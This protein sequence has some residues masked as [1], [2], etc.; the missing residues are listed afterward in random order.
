MKVRV[1]GP[2][3]QV[4]RCKDAIEGVLMG[5]EPADVLAEMDGAIIV[6][7]MDGTSIGMLSREK[8]NI[9]QKCNI[10]LE[11]DSRSIRIWAKDDNRDTAIAARDHI[12]EMLADVTTVETI[13]VR[14][15]GQKVAE[16]LNSTSMRQLQDSSGMTANVAKDDQ[17]TA[18][19]LTGLNGVINEA[20]EL[21][22]RMS[23]G[24]GAEFLPLQP[25]LL[26]RMT[27]Q[28]E[29]DFWRDLQHMSHATGAQVELS[30]GSNR[31]NFV[32]N[33][34]CTAHAKSELQKILN[35]YF[36][37]SCI[38]VSVPSHAVDYIAGDEDRELMRLQ[39]RGALVAL[40]RQN[41]QL[42]LCG[43]PRGV[44]Q[45]LNR[46][47]NMLQQWEKEYW[48]HHC[49]RGACYAVIGTGGSNIRQL[50]SET[51]AH[52][53]VDP[54]QGVIRVFGGEDAVRK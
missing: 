29:A 18:I 36:P 20:K 37:D 28:M 39:S 5:Y 44:E 15:P 22:E 4:L 43:D 10:T 47:R 2:R 35:F 19:R 49:A 16:I 13:L 9:E 23:G 30:K 8:E 38:I 46:I 50:Q 34:Q 24:G 51:G 48:E 45:A 54:D 26:L 6:R 25:G 1:S 7:N 42:W 32:G 14:V 40:D 11:V 12:D 17:G 31:A 52:I 33:P 53:Q 21:I 3:A 41:A 27:P